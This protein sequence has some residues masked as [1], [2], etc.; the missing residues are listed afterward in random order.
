MGH[1]DKSGE[2]HALPVVLYGVEYTYRERGEDNSTYELFSTLA[3]AKDWM[4]KQG[5]NYEI[6]YTFWG[7]FNPDLV[8]LDDGAWQYEDGSQTM[9]NQ[10]IIDDY[11]GHQPQAA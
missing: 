7:E 5:E 9:Y 1:Y 6:L 3:E 11:R 2:W 8:Y 10:D 4:S